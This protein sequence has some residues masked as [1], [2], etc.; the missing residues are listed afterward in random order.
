MATVL[1]TGGLGYVASYLILK[2]LQEGYTVRT[3]IRS[4]SKEE[5]IRVALQ[6]AGAVY[7][8]RLSFHPADLT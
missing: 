1:V 6:K 5:Q 8:N 3:I 7:M 2:L 4:L